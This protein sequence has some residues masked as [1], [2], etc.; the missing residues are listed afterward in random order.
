M[1]WVASVLRLEH[2]DGDLAVGLLLVVGV[3]GVRGERALPPGCAFFAGDLAG[4]V[5]L[6]DGAVPQLDARTK[7]RAANI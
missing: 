7:C 1:P 6:G 5:V 2:E 4:H 3:V